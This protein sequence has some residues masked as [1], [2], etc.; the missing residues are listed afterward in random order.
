VLLRELIKYVSEQ[1]ND[2][3]PG[4]EYSRWSK[5]LL[6]NYYNDAISALAS[7]RPDAISVVS[8]FQLSPGRLQQL[9]PELGEFVAIVDGGDGRPVRTADAVLASS[10]KKDSC[11]SM[12]VK[13]D[14]NGNPVGYIVS[15]VSY[16]TSDPNVFFVWPP[17]PIGT[18]VQVK[19][20]HRPV[21]L[22]FTLANWNQPVIFEL[23]YL[24]PI[25]SY[26]LKR[27]EELNTESA[28]SKETAR[29]HM[30]DFL[31]LM[32]QEYRQRSRANSGW[33]AGQKGNPKVRA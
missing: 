11:C 4:F 5:E 26:M 12:P 10:Y 1:L 9:P 21:A 27:A 17:V 18:S 32:D 8:S 2:Q 15:S 22:G 20:R 24:A 19:I 23:K 29:G 28:I 14:C 3:E 6:I 25:V 13:L 16:D 30:R 33:Y 31:I 7:L